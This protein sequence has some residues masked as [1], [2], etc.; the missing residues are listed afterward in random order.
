[1]THDRPWTLALFLSMAGCSTDST[2]AAADAGAHADAHTPSHHDAAVIHPGD[3]AGAS[4]D[5]VKFCTCMDQN[6]KGNV[7]SGGCL[8]A[9]AEGTASTSSKKWDLN[10]R[11]IMCT[12]VP[13]EPNNN[14]CVHAFGTSECN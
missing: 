7:F 9:C 12:L 8:A 14:H 3:A 13:A 4:A 11:Q 5:C 1:M 2:G 6:C 10:C